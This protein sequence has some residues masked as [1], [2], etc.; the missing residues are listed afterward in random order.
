M[1]L[2]LLFGAAAVALA[3]VGVYGVIAYA[4]A[5]RAGEVA[6]RLALGAT[7]GNVF[8]LVVRQGRALAIIG[9]AIGLVVAYVAGRI[10][11]SR[12]YE[13]ASDPAILSAAT[14]VV[15]AI[16]ILATLIPAWRV[17]RIDPTRVLRSE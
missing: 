15:V 14:G 2:M 4:A 9:T 17:S 8:W 11:S 1:T 3:A 10:V 7:Q 5:Q 16:A 13:V 12:L 6:I